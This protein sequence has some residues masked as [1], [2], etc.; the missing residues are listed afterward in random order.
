MIKFGH[1]LRQGLACLLAAPAML[2]VAADAMPGMPRGTAR[3]DLGSSAAIAPDGALVVVTKQGDHVLLYRSGDEGRTWSAP[4]AVNAQPEPVSGDGE[5]RPK[6]AFASDGGAVVSWTHPFPKP[7]TGSVRL[8]RADDGVHFSAPLTVHRDTREITHRFESMI[9]LPGNR[10]ILAWIDKRDLED[11]K[12][13]KAAYRGAAIYSALSVDGGRSFRPERKVADH[14]CECCRIGAAIDTDGAVAIMW[15]HVFEPNERDHAIARLTTDGVAGPVQRATFDRWRIDG[16]P[17]HGPSLAIDTRGI[18]HAV[19]FNQV[20][21]EGRVQYGRLT[22]TGEAA[23]IEGQRPVGSG[24]AEHADMAIAGAR[25]A[26]AW[27]EF[28]GEKTRLK[29]MISSDGGNRFA[30]LDVGATAGASDQPRVLANGERLLVFWR[31]AQE[32]FRVQVLQ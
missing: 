13:S 1:R 22:G 25:I 5:N 7:N 26:I 20:K 11:A 23:G 3:T 10:I 16:C 9:A 17:H 8:A 12:A 27:K 6:I 32:G 21:G 24:R 4:V 29:A 28:D 2:A 15:R 19:W 14:S 31:T 18:R 30:D